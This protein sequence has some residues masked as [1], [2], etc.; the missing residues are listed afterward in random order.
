MK[1]YFAN[2]K[3]PF[4]S[5]KVLQ[6]VLKLKNKTRLFL[7]LKPQMATQKSEIQGIG[8]NYNT[9]ILSKPE[10]FPNSDSS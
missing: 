2:F 8:V 5:Y 10:V 3:V 7:N 4:F 6:D 9:L 1:S